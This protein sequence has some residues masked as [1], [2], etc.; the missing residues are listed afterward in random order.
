MP[1]PEILRLQD[2]GK[3]YAAAAGPVTVLREV[4][5]TMR[6]GDFVLMTGPSGSGKTTLLNLAGLLDRP[7]RG[8]VWLEGIE[9]SG[10]D[11]AAQSELRA[12]HIGFVFQRF[13]LLPH[14]TALENVLFRL[15]YI[16][17]APAG[18]RREEAR[19]WLRRFGLA[20]AADRTARLLSAGE[21]QRVALA[22]AVL[23]RPRL[24]LADEPTGN[25]DRAAAENVWA[26]LR[27]LNAEGLATLVV[28]HNESLLAPGMRHMT[29]RDGIVREV[30]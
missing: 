19:H 15:R 11:D 7:T 18:D 10:L 6:A 30:A 3:T 1:S 28:T 5:L 12:R 29:C 8:Q 27:E 13:C 21:M 14:R 9:A 22:R 2:A 24:L 25:L 20:H 26:C 17:P 4:S 16:R 23:A